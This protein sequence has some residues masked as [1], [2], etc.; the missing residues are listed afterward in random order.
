M[1]NGDVVKRLKELALF[2]DMAGIQFKPRAMEKAAA[3]IDAL[4]RPVGEIYASGG[5]KGLMEIPNVGKGIAERTEELIKTGKIQELENYRTETPVDLLT[6]TSIEGLGPKSVK[7]LYKELGVTDLDSLEAA[8]KAGRIRALPRFGEKSEQKI[9]RGIEF[10]RQDK[11][12][13]PIGRVL[14]LSREI[15]RRLAELPG[16]ERAQGA[17]SIR[18]RKESIGDLDF[19][20]ISP[21]AEPIMDFFCK[22]PEVV[23]VHARGPTKSMVRLA[24]GIDADLRVVPRESFGAALAYFTGSKDHNVTLRKIAIEKGLKLN[25]YGLFKVDGDACVASETEESI[26]AALDLQYVPP[27]MREM[28]GEVDLAKARKLPKLVEKGDLLGDCQTQ[29]KWSDGL[30]TIEEMVRAAIKLGRKWMV[31]T[32]H[33]Q[34]LA[35]MGMSEA[36]LLEQLVEIKKLQKKLDKEKL[37]FRILTGAEVN[38]RKD[39][40]LDTSDEV[41]AKLDC[42][43]VA[44]HSAFTLTKEEMT[45]RIVKAMHNPHADIYFHPTARSIGKRPAVEVDLDAL[46]EAAKKTGTI[47]EIDAHPERL[48][49]KDD[50][51]HRVLQAGVK[52]TIDSDAHA[53]GELRYPDDFGIG[54][55]RRAWAT[56][57]DVLNTLPADQFLEALK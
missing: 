48:D 44:V 1:D 49:L 47:L 37:D 38:I 45:A 23:G 24:T 33:T 9:L 43:G 53:T 3:S 57:A 30:N 42:V 5:V 21:N 13:V 52:V 18:R 17:G 6:L 2:M 32:D 54:L 28:K 35:M 25:E 4:D 10:M 34:D 8:A 36:K 56:K 55:A 51:A 16:V 46:I 39:G 40:T 50:H 22:M 20:V 7:T 31:V 29:T 12:R 15:E 14:D 19:L 41:L 11:G 26:Y 27:E